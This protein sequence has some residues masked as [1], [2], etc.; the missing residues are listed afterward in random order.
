EDLSKLVQDVDFDFMDLN[1]PKGDEPIIIQD[2]SD[3]E[4]H[5]EKSQNQKLKKLKSKPEAEVS[6]LTAQPSF[7]NVE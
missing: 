4:H 6:F 2:E 3:E 7:P 5:A 1:S